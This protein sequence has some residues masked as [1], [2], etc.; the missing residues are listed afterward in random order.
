[1]ASLSLL[2]FDFDNL[3]SAEGATF[4]KSG[5]TPDLVITRKPSLACLTVNG[6]SGDNPCRGYGRGRL[7]RQ[8]PV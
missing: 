2:L 5:C 7:H 6:I 3:I 4:F 8:S 1:M